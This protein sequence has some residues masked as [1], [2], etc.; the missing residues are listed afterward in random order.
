MPDNSLEEYS[1]APVWKQFAP[2]SI[3]GFNTADIND[4]KADDACKAIYYDL[5]GTYIGHDRSSLSPGIYIEHASGKS[6]KIT[7]K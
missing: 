5:K 1:E 4:I 2:F 3:F 7:I 6:R